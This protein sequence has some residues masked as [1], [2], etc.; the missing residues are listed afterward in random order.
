MGA[1]A[2]LFGQSRLHHCTVEDLQHVRHAVHSVR[3]HVV[4]RRP[5]LRQPDLQQHRVDV[6]ARY[7]RTATRLTATRSDGHDPHRRCH[8]PSTVTRWL[9]PVTT[10]EQDASAECHRFANPNT[11]D[12]CKLN[13]M[14]NAQQGW[15]A[16]WRAIGTG[17][18]SRPRY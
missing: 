6:T 7:A 15:N 2:A 8:H 4:N 13:Y 17:M 1:S 18:L 3:N 14:N 5:A 12:I 9:R 11:R 16:Q 10:D